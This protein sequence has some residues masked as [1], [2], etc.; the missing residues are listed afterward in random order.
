MGSAR[1]LS[2]HARRRAN[3]AKE[4]LRI[5]VA[6]ERSTRGGPDYLPLLRRELL[7]GHP[8]VRQRRPRSDPDQL[9]ARGRPRSAGAVGGAAGSAGDVEFSPG[10]GLSAVGRALARQRRRSR[11]EARPTASSSRAQGSALSP[12]PP[13]TASARSTVFSSA[14]RCA[15][16]QIDLRLEQAAP[17]VEQLEVRD[18]A[19]AVAQLRQLRRTR[20]RRDLLRVRVARSRDQRLTLQAHRAPRGMPSAPSART[21]PCAAR[22]PPWSRAT[23]ARRRPPW[24]S[25]CTMPADRGPRFRGLGEQVAELG[26]ERAEQRR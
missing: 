9:R 5:I 19:L 15:A 24:N 20:Q 17:H 14:S 11:A 10:A 22:E 7:R 13:P 18:V 8:Q 25:G 4:R 16:T 2:P 21:P 26:A 3:V 1:T 23:F 12:S 6:Q